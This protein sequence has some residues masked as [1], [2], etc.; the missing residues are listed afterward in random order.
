MIMYGSLLLRMLNI[1]DEI[2]QKN[3]NP[4]VCSKIFSSENRAL[5]EAM[6]QNMVEVEKRQMAL[7]YGAC[8]LH[9]G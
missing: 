9:T 7:Q 5:C 1:L 8:A 2:C 3:E 6:W 4:H